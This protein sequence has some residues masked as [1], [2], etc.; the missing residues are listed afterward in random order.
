LEIGQGEPFE[1]P[2]ET[3]FVLQGKQDK[4]EWEGLRWW[5]VR[6]FVK[7]LGQGKKQIPHRHSQRTRLGSG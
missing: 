4:R 3:P 6:E 1:A 7:Q 5:S 2:F